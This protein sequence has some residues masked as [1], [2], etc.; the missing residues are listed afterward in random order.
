M[1]KDDEVEGTGNSY[2]THFRQYDSRLGRWGSVD[3]EEKEN[4]SQSSYCGLDNNPIKIV[5]PD[6]DNGWDIAA[7]IVIGGLSDFVP[8]TITGGNPREL[9]H[10]TDPADYNNTLQI[11]DNFSDVNSKA[12][13]INGAGAMAVGTTVTIGSGGTLT[14]VAAPVAVAGAVVAG[15]GTVQAYGTNVNKSRGYN[16]GE[17]KPAQSQPTKEQTKAN[18]EKTADKTN[19][20][21]SAQARA[22]KLSQKERPGKDFTKSGK[23]AV[24]DVNKAQNNGQM[25]CQNC[26]TNTNNPQQHTQ[27][28]KPPANEAH[29]DHVIPKSKGGSGTPNNGQVLCRDCNLQKSNK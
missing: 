26:G 14:V 8:Y 12:A 2:T 22:D 5:D 7:G 10:P 25:K 23:E 18:T 9:Y 6:G 20:K 13:I 4:E 17:Q 16:Y 11:V 28:Y 27:G 19:S 29:V 21:N 15:A 1:E 24:K 3:P